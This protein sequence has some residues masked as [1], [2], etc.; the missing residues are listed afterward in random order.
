MRT[1]IGFEAAL[2]E[3]ATMTAPGRMAGWVRYAVVPPVAA[4]DGLSSDSGKV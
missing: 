1:P 3:A 4:E 2:V